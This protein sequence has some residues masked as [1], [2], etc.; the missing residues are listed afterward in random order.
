MDTLQPSRDITKLLWQHT[1]QKHTQAEL[2][3]GTML[4]ATLF[5]PSGS[6]KT[7]EW[8]TIS[9]VLSVENIE[10]DKDSIVQFTGD[11]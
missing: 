7:G 11:L 2:G 4:E 1:N 6:I 10:L 3:E 5:V 9:S 8:A